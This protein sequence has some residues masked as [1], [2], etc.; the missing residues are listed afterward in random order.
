MGLYL[1]TALFGGPQGVPVQQGAEN[2]ALKKP[3]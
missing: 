2:T 1:S 3:E